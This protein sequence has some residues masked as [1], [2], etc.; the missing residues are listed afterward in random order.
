M[1]NEGGRSTGRELKLVRSPKKSKY[2][3]IYL[4]H[5]H[6][7]VSIVGQVIQHNIVQVQVESSIN[8]DKKKA[9]NISRVLH[10]VNTFIQKPIFEKLFLNKVLYGKSYRSYVI[11]QELSPLQL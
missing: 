2:E 1:S 5:V 3:K 4:L 11:H 9:Q 8:I 7:H 6:Q 10:L